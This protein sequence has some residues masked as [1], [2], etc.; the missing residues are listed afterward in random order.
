MLDLK[1]IRVAVACLATSASVCATGAFADATLENAFAPSPADLAN[2][3]Y[4]GYFASSGIHGY[5]TFCQDVRTGNI[6]SYQLAG[7]YLQQNYSM[8]AS[9]F[10][11]N[12]TMCAGTYNPTQGTKI[13]DLKNDPK[14]PDL[15]NGQQGQGQISC[16]ANGMPQI[17]VEQIFSLRDLNA[18]D[19]L[20]RITCLHH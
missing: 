12:N 16:G 8:Y 5:A 6:H 14:A 4:Q 13:P 19:D 15:G 9:H 11:Y 3:G 7:A 17:A 2:L 10:G 1:L 18:T 20:M